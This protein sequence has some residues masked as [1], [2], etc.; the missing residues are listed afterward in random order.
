MTNQVTEYEKRQ[1]RVT[2]QAGNV[3]SQLESAYKESENLIGLIK[4][5]QS[6]LSEIRKKLWITII[7]VAL[8]IAGAIALK[9]YI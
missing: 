8:V 6:E 1:R 7:V 4:K 2:E 9:T 3:Y 5:K